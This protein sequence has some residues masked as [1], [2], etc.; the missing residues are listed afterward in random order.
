MSR[1]QTRGTRDARRSATTGPSVARRAFIGLAGGAAAAASLGVLAAR[2]VRAD[3]DTEEQTALQGVPRWSDAFK[4]GTVDVDGLPMHMAVSA[5]PR[6]DAGTLVLVH[7]LALSGTYM[8][9][10]AEELARDYRVYVPDFP[11]FGD[12]GKPD[13]ILDVPGLADWLVAWMDA[14]GLERAMMLG[15]SFG[16]Q[17][18][19][20]AAARYPERVERAVLQGPTTPADERTW[21]WQFVR[22]RQNAPHNPPGMEQIADADYAKCGL[23]RA[24]LTF[25]FSLRDALEEKLPRVPQP[26]LVV[27]GSEDPIC[28]QGW[29][30]QLA[31]GLP[32]GTLT[33]MPEVAHTL[34]YTS[35]PELAAV[36]RPFLDQN[37]GAAGG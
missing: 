17:I 28:R 18:I 12:S 30:E 34:V 29:A 21:I 16:C 37:E 5:A 24:L 1:R 3:E 6:P 23:V 22:W 13:R 26:M 7:G 35:G 10:V 15:N 9:P 11:G 27:R 19:V 4:T 33:V 2:R 25:E 8:I 14:V 36:S 31:E 32:D 20:E